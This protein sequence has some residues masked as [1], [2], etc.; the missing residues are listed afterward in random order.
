MKIENELIEFLESQKDDEVLDFMNIRWLTT[1]KGQQMTG[2]FY[3][4]KEHFIEDLKQP[5]DKVSNRRSM[6]FDLNFKRMMMNGIDP[7][8]NIKP[9]KER[10]WLKYNFIENF[11]HPDLNVVVSDRRIGRESFKWMKDPYSVKNEYFKTIITRCLNGRNKEHLYKNQ[12]LIDLLNSSD[13]EEQI[14]HLVKQGLYFYTTLYNISYPDVETRELSFDDR[15]MFRGIE[16]TYERDGFYDH[17]E[18]RYKK[19]I[20]KFRKDLLGIEGEVL[21]YSLS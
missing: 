10:F 5:K 8:N 19:E 1:S 14:R 18:E 3:L 15:N 4:T 9:Y 2:N 16:C 12:L 20:I 21:N 13:K 11:N 6:I 17:W 7:L